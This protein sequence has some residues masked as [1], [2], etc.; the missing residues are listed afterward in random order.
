MQAQGVKLGRGE[1]LLS[2][3][4][5]PNSTTPLEFTFIMKKCDSLHKNNKTIFGEKH[6]APFKN[7]ISF[8]SP[9]LYVDLYTLL[10][11]KG[12]EFYIK[13]K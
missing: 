1:G 13:T 12:F 2:N 4:L 7:K 11:F 9:K 10:E 8:Y 3:R 5:V 6:F